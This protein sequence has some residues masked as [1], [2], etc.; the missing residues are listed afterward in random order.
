MISG[1]KHQK[2]FVQSRD[3]NFETE[4]VP[5]AFRFS[6]GTSILLGQLRQK[7]DLCR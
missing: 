1:M 7:R 2:I 3:E 6:M 5:F 4:F